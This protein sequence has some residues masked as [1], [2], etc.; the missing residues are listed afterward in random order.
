M[1]GLSQRLYSE[2]VG[3]QY[4]EKEDPYGWREKIG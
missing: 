3:I 1:G 2:I 4:A